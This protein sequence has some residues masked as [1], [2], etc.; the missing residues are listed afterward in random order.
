MEQVI[1][2]ENVTSIDGILDGHNSGYEKH[3]TYRK[4]LRWTDKYP[5]DPKNIKGMYRRL[6][7]QAD[8]TE[9]NVEKPT[10]RNR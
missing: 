10:D 4:N 8:Q 2:R 6:Y 5:E 7:L 9:E 1:E 3:M